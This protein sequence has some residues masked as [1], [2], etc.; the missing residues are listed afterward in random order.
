MNPETGVEFM[1]R[2][3]QEVS[4]VLFRKGSPEYQR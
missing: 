4:I 1:D 2:V 3:V